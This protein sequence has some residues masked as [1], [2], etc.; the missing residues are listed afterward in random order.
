MTPQRLTTITVTGDDMAVLDLARRVEDHGFIP[1]AL[2]APYPFSEGVPSLTR[3]PFTLIAEGTFSVMF[4]FS[5]CA[6]A[7]VVEVATRFSEEVP[8]AAVVL[9]GWH[10]ANVYERRELF[11]GVVTEVITETAIEY[12]C[13]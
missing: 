1:M 9:F 13:L 11:E 10:D 6:F 7:S 8:S 4:T 5:P 12:G 2:T 3:S